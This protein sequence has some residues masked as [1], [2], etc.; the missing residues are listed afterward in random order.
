MFM[1]YLV[2]KF[3]SEQYWIEVGNDG[4]ALRQIII[5]ADNNEHVSCIEDC[6]AEGVIGESRILPDQ[7][8]KCCE[9]FPQHLIR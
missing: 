7:Q 1:K 4:Y 9:F 2:T 8:F 5:D 6:L 3:D